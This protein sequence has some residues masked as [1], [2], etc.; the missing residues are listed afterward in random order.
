MGEISIC[1]FIRHKCPFRDA[2]VRFC[3]A[4]LDLSDRRLV[5][6]LSRVRYDRVI[7]GRQHWERWCPSV[8][9]ELPPW[10]EQRFQR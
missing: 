3:V 2:P 9:P 5:M 8:P 10:L 6:V 4:R 1:K 7:L